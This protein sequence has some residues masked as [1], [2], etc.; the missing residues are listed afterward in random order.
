M[1]N[2][3]I[4]KGADHVHQRVGVLVSR[5]V[6]Q[7]LRAAAAGAIRS[8]NS[9]VAGTR[10]RGLCIAVSVSSR[11][12]GPWRCPIADVALA[13]R[14]SFALVISWKRVVCRWRNPIRAARSTS[15]P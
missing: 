4:P 14:G 8:V 15:Q 6:D 5:H 12:S 3:R 7:R 2:R 10:F 9:T 1:R 11:A 13:A